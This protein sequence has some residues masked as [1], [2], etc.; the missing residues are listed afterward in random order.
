MT[1]LSTEWQLMIVKLA[2]SYKILQPWWRLKMN[3]NLQPFCRKTGYCFH[4][5]YS[6]VDYFN[7]DIIELWDS[8]LK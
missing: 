8:S 5:K 7:Y 6:R 2:F 4:N 1:P 3:Q